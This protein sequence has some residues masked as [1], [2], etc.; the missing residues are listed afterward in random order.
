MPTVGIARVHAKTRTAARKTLT[1]V[2]NVCCGKVLH[3]NYRS[4]EACDARYVP[5]DLVSIDV[6]FRLQ[7][8]SAVTLSKALN[9]MNDK[10]LEY[11]ADHLVRALDQHL[12]GPPRFGRH[13]AGWR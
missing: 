9:H 4:D 3:H 7:I 13:V 10:P 5:N 12:D 1:K 8:Q 2:A 6:R 11:L